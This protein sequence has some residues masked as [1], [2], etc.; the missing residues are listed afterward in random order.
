MIKIL[1]NS[2]SSEASLLG[3]KP[4]AFSS[5]LR[6]VFP[7]TRVYGG[8]EGMSMNSLGSLIRILILLDPGLTLL[9]LFNLNYFLRGPISKNSHTGSKSFNM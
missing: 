9:I 1:A 2:I 8:G 7:L 6:M 3:L 5:C 4:A